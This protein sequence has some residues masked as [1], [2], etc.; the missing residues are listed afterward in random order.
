MAGRRAPHDRPG[1][2]PGARRHG[3]KVLYGGTFRLIRQRA[4][5][6]A[7]RGA[8]HAGALRNARRG[9]RGRKPGACRRP[10][11]PSACC[12]DDREA[13]CRGLP[14]DLRV[15]DAALG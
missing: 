7:A 8:R 9:R 13:A 11:H 2:R 5:A 14:S 3:G 10:V 1:G 6:A 12:A 15:V 4:P